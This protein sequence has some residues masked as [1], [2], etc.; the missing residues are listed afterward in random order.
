MAE[1][2]S[3]CAAAIITSRFDTQICLYFQYDWAVNIM[4]EPAFWLLLCAWTAPASGEV[5]SKVTCL[6]LD[7]WSLIPSLAA[8]SLKAGGRWVEVLQVWWSIAHLGSVLDRPHLILVAMRTKMQLRIVQH[9]AQV[10]A[11]ELSN[12]ILIGKYLQGG[13]PT[14][15]G[16]AKCNVV[17]RANRATFTK[18]WPNKKGENLYFDPIKR[19]KI[20]ILTQ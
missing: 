1:I 9:Q 6:V 3:G 16:Y 4:C 10:Q 20:C 8:A 11:K 7:P 13:I 15:L 12:G 18:Y 2:K 5:Q 19:G 14:S 17:K